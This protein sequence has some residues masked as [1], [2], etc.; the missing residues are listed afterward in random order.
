[1]NDFNFDKMKNFNTPN[2]WAEKAKEIPVITETKTPLFVFRYPR[3]FAVA[4][5]FL[6]VVVLSVSFFVFKPDED[7]L[8]VATNA[9]NSEETAIRTENTHPTDNTKETEKEFESGGYVNIEPEE[10]EPQTQANT[11][12]KP[13]QKPTSSTERI[14]PS[15]KPSETQPQTQNQTEN[16]TQTPSTVPMPSD[17]PSDKVDKNDI[18]VNVAIYKHLVLADEKI[19]CR[20]YD[21]KGVLLGDPDLYSEEHLTELI[22]STYY[23]VRYYPYRHS[24]ITKTGFYTFVFYNSE[25]AIAQETTIYLKE[26]A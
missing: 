9:Q 12:E 7:I 2:E 17:P 5:S 18:Y 14:E 6:F 11:S 25:G 1:M 19:F 26:D 15:E 10:S 23:F 13:T 24:L 4:M 22:F 16:L 20:V 21:E 8:P 3:A